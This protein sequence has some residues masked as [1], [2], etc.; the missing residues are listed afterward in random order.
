MGEQKL[1]SHTSR[2][3]N[4]RLI[5]RL[6]EIDMAAKRAMKTKNFHHIESFFDSCELLY[7]NVKDILPDDMIR[8]TDDDGEPVG[9][10][11]KTRRDFQNRVDNLTEE[12]KGMKTI[13]YCLRKT[14]KFY[15]QLITALQQKQ[16]FFRENTPSKRLDDI[17][18]QEENVFQ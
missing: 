4:K 8:K 2:D 16:F 1:S 17:D 6:N 7:I 15:S 14:K 12:Q 11:E 18:F 5:T 10:I 9:G 3:N 13:R